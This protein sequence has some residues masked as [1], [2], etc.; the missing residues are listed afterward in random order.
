MSCNASRGNSSR[1]QPTER[2]WLQNPNVDQGQILVT[3]RA[4]IIVD[5]DA[6]FEAR[7]F[8]ERLIGVTLLLESEEKFMNLTE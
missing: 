8:D 5:R 3:E 2:V 4:E 7:I 1:A 6:A